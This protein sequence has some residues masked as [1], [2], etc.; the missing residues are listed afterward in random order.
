LEQLQFTKVRAKPPMKCGFRLARERAK[1]SSTKRCFFCATK[2][3]AKMTCCCH[4]I[5]MV[6]K[7][8]KKLAKQ[9]SA[10]LFWQE[11]SLT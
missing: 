9:G 7:K 5:F 11:F 1:T 4:S 8:I 3:Q 2:K 6:I 10:G